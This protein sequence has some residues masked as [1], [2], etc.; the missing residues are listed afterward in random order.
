MACILTYSSSIFPRLGW[1][2]TRLPGVYA[3]RSRRAHIA[4]KASLARSSRCTRDA[5]S[6]RNSM[7]SA[8]ERKRATAFAASA[9][10]SSCR[11]RDS[12]NMNKSQ[13]TLRFSGSTVPGSPNSEESPRF[14]AS[15]SNRRFVTNAGLGSRCSS[16]T[17]YPSGTLST[18]G[19]APPGGTSSARTNKCARSRSF[20]PSAVASPDSTCRETR[21]GRPCSSHVY[22][23]VLTP[24]I[25][26]T[27]SRRSPG[28]RRRPVQPKP[29]DWGDRRSRLLRKNAASSRC[30]CSDSVTSPTSSWPI[31]ASCG[32]NKDKCR[33]GG[34]LSHVPRAGYWR[35]AAVGQRAVVTAVR[36]EGAFVKQSASR[37]L[38]VWD[39]LQI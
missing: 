17:R 16:R 36:L 9:S 11:A 14:Q 13:R 39:V 27:S 30:R 15:T 1:R 32:S 23:E 33:A 18:T 19:R 20:N 2:S 12:G 6:G 26:A 3:I 4:R 28:V 31:L 38:G 34:L 21:I 8:S 24:A 29:A 37:I 10:Q 7:S 25:A 5:N 35:A 22:Q